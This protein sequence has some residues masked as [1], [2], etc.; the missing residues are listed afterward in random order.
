MKCKG[1][2]ERKGE[3]SIGFTGFEV[4]TSLTQHVPPP[5]PG[6]SSSSALPTATPATAPGCLDSQSPPIPGGMVRVR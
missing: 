1:R 6:P 5:R 2:R 3:T 4:I